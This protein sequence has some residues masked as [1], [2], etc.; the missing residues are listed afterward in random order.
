M[1]IFLEKITDV[2]KVKKMN[3]GFWFEFLFLIKHALFF[4]MK[5]IIFHR[6]NNMKILKYINIVF[7]LKNSRICLCRVHNWLILVF[8]I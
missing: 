5:E 8:H 6:Y 2:I 7:I 4:T 1:F 3:F